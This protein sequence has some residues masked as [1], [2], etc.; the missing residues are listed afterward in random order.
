MDIRMNKETGDAVFI[1]GPLS[2]SGITQSAQDVVAQR[3]T[4]RLR[5]FLGDWFI[6]TAY[7][8]PYFERILT[9][10]VSKTTVDNIFREQILTESGV[11][12]IQEFTSAFSAGARTYSCNFTVLTREGSASVTITV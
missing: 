4:I 3:L 12:E 10:N 8:L 2:L 5:S 7:G 1:N 6:N 11:L 9:K